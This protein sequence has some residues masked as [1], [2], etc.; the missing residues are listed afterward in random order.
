M[1]GACLLSRR[2]EDVSTFFGRAS[3]DCEGLLD[4]WFHYELPEDVC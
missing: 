1:R 3:V 4:Y 2:G